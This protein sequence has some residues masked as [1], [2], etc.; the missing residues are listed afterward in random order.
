MSLYPIRII[1]EALDCGG[2]DKPIMVEIT[3]FGV[4]L[5]GHEFKNDWC[6]LSWALLLDDAGYGEEVCEND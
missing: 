5:I 1:L 2:C 6:I 3:P 4:E